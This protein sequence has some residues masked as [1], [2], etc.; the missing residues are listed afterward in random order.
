MIRHIIRSY[1]HCRLD[2]FSGGRLLANGLQSLLAAQFARLH[3]PG[4]IR[5]EL[6]WGLTPLRFVSRKTATAQD[7]HKEWARIGWEGQWMSFSL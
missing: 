2:Q 4:G 7:A 6:F 1:S 3:E 5:D